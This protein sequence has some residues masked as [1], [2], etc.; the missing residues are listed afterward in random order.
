MTTAI[1]DHLAALDWYPHHL[2]WLAEQGMSP[3]HTPGDAAP[4]RADL[5][6]ADLRGVDLRDADM[7][8][9]LLERALLTGA[10]LR[11]A[12]LDGADLR[13]AVLDGTCLIDADLRDADLR[14]ADLRDAG[15]RGADLRGAHL[16]SAVLDGANLTAANLDG[17]NLAGADLRLAN[18][19][20]A[21][22]SGA[23][24]IPS[25]ADAVALL[26]EIRDIVLA[27]PYR[28]SMSSWHE[29]DDRQY[30]CGTAHCV[31]GWAQCLRQLPSIDDA[32][33]AIWP[34]AHMIYVDDATALEAL[35][36]RIYA[37]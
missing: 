19:D 21:D 37:D 29:D 26:D 28:L 4:R 24:G 5:H 17:A 31:A 13:G 10:D 27:D 30:D 18:L 25:R 33:R 11:G 22:L 15:L 8:G 35:R 7:R 1:P 6:G 16:R 14:G 36:S 12:I 2:A 3:R 9:A 20:D 23:I 32:V 34:M